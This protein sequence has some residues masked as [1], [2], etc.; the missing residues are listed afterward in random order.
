LFSP[1]QTSFAGDGQG[2]ACEW[3]APS[4][5][6]FFQK[7]NKMSNMR[8]LTLLL[9]KAIDDKTV[10]VAQL[11]SAANVT[12]QAIYNILKGHE[13]VSIDVVEKLAECVGATV[14]IEIPKRSIRKKS[15]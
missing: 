15:A 12:R 8:A 10:T 2:A 5:V 14:R 7:A 11:A 13:K 4:I 9:Q 1:R 6:D 3:H